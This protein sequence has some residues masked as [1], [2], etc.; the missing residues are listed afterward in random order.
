MTQRQ[1]GKA[2]RLDQA[3]V[4]RYKGREAPSEEILRRMAKVVGID[5]SLVVHLR[6][7]CSSFLASASRGDVHLG[8]EG[9]APA[10]LEPVLLA[11]FPYL[12][13]LGKIESEGQL[14]K[15]ARRE[16]GQIWE[17]LSRA[18]RSRDVGGL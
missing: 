9:L 12:V 1:F 11:L 8:E 5:W 4:S 10:I 18:S 17:V 14:P 6:Q 7:F 13:E 16:A 3:Q 15:E 2:C